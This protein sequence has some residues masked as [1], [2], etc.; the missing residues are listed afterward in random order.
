MSSFDRVLSFI[1]VMEDEREKR[2]D[3]EGRQCAAQWKKAR[4]KRE[5]SEEEGR[6]FLLTDMSI[7]SIRGGKMRKKRVE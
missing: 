2:G 5:S 1:K 4:G 7:G 6:G 3:E